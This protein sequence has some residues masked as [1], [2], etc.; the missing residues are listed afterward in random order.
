MQG[1]KRDTDEKATGKNGTQADSGPET[2]GTRGTTPE[3]VSP[4][5]TCPLRRESKRDGACNNTRGGKHK[6]APVQETRKNRRA[7]KKRGE[8]KIAFL[9]LQGG[10]KAGK[11][12][13]AFQMLQDDKIGIFAVTETHLRDEERPPDC[14]GLFL[15]WGKQRGQ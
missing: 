3:D 2:T 11:W 6:K 13:E 10:R 7:K 8:V 4:T 12:E 9:N 1:E 14:E 15:G 5:G